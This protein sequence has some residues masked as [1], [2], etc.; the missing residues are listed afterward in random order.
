M[1]TNKKITAIPIAYRDEGNIEELYKRLTKVLS[2]ITRN[3]E[4]IYVNDSSPDK[5]QEILI[6]GKSS[7]VTL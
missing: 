3:Y 4:I 7:G 5:S 6:D 2:K 1:L